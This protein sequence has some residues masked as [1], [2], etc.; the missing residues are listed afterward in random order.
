[1]LSR[2][3]REPGLPARG[4]GPS[5]RRH[6]LTFAGLPERVRTSR[7]PGKLPN[8]S[9]AIARIQQIE[10]GR[11]SLDLHHDGA[12]HRPGLRPGRGP[13]RLRAAKLDPQPERGQR[14]H[15][16]DR[17]GDPARRGRL[18]GAP[19]QDDRHGRRRPGDP[20]LRLPRPHHGRR[21]RARR[22]A[23]GRLRLHRHEHLGARQRAH[24]AGRHQGHRPG[25][26]RRLQ[27][28]RD[29]RHA[30]RRPRPDRR[31]RVLLVRQRRRRE[32]RPGHRSSRCSASPSAP[33]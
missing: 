32:G 28:R 16:G 21:L 5:R 25:A 8:E 2:A 1:M 30:G 17:R 12:L 9:R 33:R 7:R 3:S 13:L 15:A 31:R 22:R 6:P 11:N 20:D 4:P 27:G 29:H 18:P 10:R 24:R 26:R 23:L 14:A 19:V